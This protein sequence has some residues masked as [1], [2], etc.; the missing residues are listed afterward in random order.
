[1]CLLFAV[2]AHAI[3]VRAGLLTVFIFAAIINA[4]FIYGCVHIADGLFLKKQEAATQ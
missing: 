4:I 2:I 3:Y 1:L